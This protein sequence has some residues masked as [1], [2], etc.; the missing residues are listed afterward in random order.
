MKKNLI[1][2]LA[3]CLV[4]ISSCTLPDNLKTLLIDDDST[5]AE[6]PFDESPT[7]SVLI[8]TPAAP[9]T[10]QDKMDAAEFALFSGEMESAMQLFQD[11]YNQNTDDES[12]ANA[13][14]GIGRT[15]YLNRNYSAAIDSFNRLLGQFPSSSSIAKAYFLLGEAYFDIQEY[16]QSAN[17]YAKYSELQPK[18]IDDLVYQYQGDAAF[19][20]GNFQQA[21]LAY[22]SALQASPPGNTAYLTIQIGK[23]YSGLGDF[24]N[25][26]QYFLSVYNSEADDYS[27]ATANLLAGQAYLELGMD[28]DAYTRFLDSVIKFPNAYDSFTA[29]T[30]LVN[31]G[32]P[33]DE[34][35]RGLV[36]YHANSYDAAI[37]A[38]E[39]Y[40]ASNPE[41]ID[42]SVYYYLGLS[43]FYK[44][45]FQKAIDAYQTMIENY[46]GNPLWDQAWEELAFTYW[47]DPNDFYP[48]MSDYESSVQTRL[49]FVSKATTSPLAPE[50]LFIAGR[51]LESNNQLERAAQIWQRMM[52][53]YPSSELSYR[54]LFLAGISYFRLERFDEALS[55]FQRSLVLGT[56]PSE[57][58]RAYLWIGKC[59]QA[60]G[61][62]ENA[63]VYWQSGQLAD[64]TNYYSIR[65]GELFEGKTPFLIDGT[66]DLGYDLE[67]EKNEAESWLRTT[68]AIP[69][70]TSLTGLG[71]LANDYRILRIKTLM[72]LG[73]YGKAGQ[74]AESLR[75][76]LSSDVVRTYQLMNFLLELGLYQ[77]AIYA[78]RDIINKTGADDLSSLS[79][80][81]FFSHV[82]FGIYFREMMVPIANEY[83]IHPLLL[84]SLIRQESMFNPFAG[85][86]AGALGLAQIIP[87]TGKDN[88]DRLGW[89]AD[90]QTADL[91]KG[92]VSI[93]LG[94]FYLSRLRSIFN[95]NTQYALAAY[96]GGQGSVL[97][98]SQLNNNDPD[99]FLETVRFQETQT[100]L[101][102]IAEFLNIYKLIYLRR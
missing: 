21:I 85:S 50:F 81:I 82:R 101:R 30:Y 79:A 59:L 62:I 61:D 14:F 39:R 74:E 44:E 45:Q 60:K 38:F 102:Q 32:V 10:T 27:K 52:D 41:S 47:N 13:L 49:D 8:P 25:A 69:T 24:T 22:Q 66:Y 55:I 84:Y 75:Q 42:G 5:S 98:W 29:L 35:L 100:Y 7:V 23:S 97:I 1:R 77:P 83:E 72:G 53:E 67:L 96:N 70:E 20:A 17:A 16:Q 95:E 78:C 63:K 73:L 57:K 11:T 88:A 89:P 54:G 28:N 36:D 48:G 90:F 6:T 2:L 64:P 99:L 43:Y 56:A 34:Y 51:T 15:H 65:S 40:I 19:N 3:A 71:D 58:A 76:Q 33:V 87:S 46:P 31:A 37:L 91:Y 12:R 93:T 92:E 4:I 26:I 9:L 68:F 80:P 86:G 94:T 18:A